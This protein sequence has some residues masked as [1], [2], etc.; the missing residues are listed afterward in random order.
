MSSS[1]EF[2]RKLHKYCNRNKPHI[3]VKTFEEFI[4]DNI[5]KKDTVDRLLIWSIGNEDY[6]Y[7]QM[8][9]EALLYSYDT[10][11][12]I[13]HL[14][15][16]FHLAKGYR[17]YERKSM[18]YQGFVESRKTHNHCSVILLCLPDKNKKLLKEITLSM[19]KSCGWF[20]A[21]KLDKV[22]LDNHEGWQFEKKKDNDATHE[23]KSH[24]YIYH[25]CPKSRLQKILHVGLSPKKTTW[26]AYKL[27]KEHTLQDKHN[28]HYGWKTVDRVYA[29]LDKPDEEF[30][31]DNNFN[32]K[33][34]NSPDGYILLSIDISKLQSKIKFSFDPRYENAVFTL[35]NIPP[36][37]I[38][39]VDTK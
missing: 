37:A 1:T 26:E 31:E 23:V 20:L 36:S 18:D 4:A 7:P 12:V 13:R 19:E 35:E 33:E 5:K 14:C 27:D 34:I 9:D 32:E 22:D 2:I 16:T 39:V 38:S 29:F 28:Q 8:V 11:R 17:K 21:R 3:M 25:L 24:D 15:S 10:S 30:L 6:I